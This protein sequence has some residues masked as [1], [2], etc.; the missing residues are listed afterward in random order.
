MIIGKI[1]IQK[2]RFLELG[3]AKIGN[4]WR[5]LNLVDGGAATIGPCYTSKAELL[6]DLYRYAKEYGL[7]E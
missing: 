6:A 2:T 4:D 7:T 5:F 1:K 3:Y